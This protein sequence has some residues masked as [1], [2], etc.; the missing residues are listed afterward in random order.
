[1]GGQSHREMIW[2]SSR[3]TYLKDGNLKD[4]NLKNG[5]GL[6]WAGMWTRGVGNRGNSDHS[7]IFLGSVCPGQWAPTASASEKALRQNAYRQ[8]YAPSYISK[9]WAPANVRVQCLA[10]EKECW[11]KYGSCP[12]GNHSLVKYYVPDLMGK[13]VNEV[14]RGMKVVQSCWNIEGDGKTG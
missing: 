7:L 3:P 5:R 14:C 10:L 1:M 2:I 4:G 13:E 8:R 6:P 11:I 12:Y 9:Y